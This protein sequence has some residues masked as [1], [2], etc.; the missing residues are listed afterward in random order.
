M[1]SV[2]SGPWRPWGE[3]EG[4]GLVCRPP[5]AWG[6]LASPPHPRTGQPPRVWCCE[7]CSC[8]LTC[9][10]SPLPL[11]LSLVLGQQEGME[12]SCCWQVSEARAP[13]QW[14]WLGGE[15]VNKLAFWVQ[16][17]SLPVGD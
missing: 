2:P 15:L 6:R 17:G 13:P 3:T 1:P 14:Y 12:V 10:S 11:Q 4:Q 8:S 5:H 7:P 9:C 16:A